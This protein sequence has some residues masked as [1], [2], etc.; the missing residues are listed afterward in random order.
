VVVVVEV[1]S[2]GKMAPVD[3]MARL[4]GLASDFVGT[5]ASFVNLDLGLWEI[6]DS[7]LARCFAYMDCL[8]GL[9]PGA[10][11]AGDTEGRSKRQVRENSAMMRRG[12]DTRL[13]IKHLLTSM[14]L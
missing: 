3:N 11:S 13:N 1:M 9:P 14:K 12:I 2:I 8:C 5:E 4:V 7:A 6:V 10:A